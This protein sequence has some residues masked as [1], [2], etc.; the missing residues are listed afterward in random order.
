M[1]FSFFDFYENVLKAY[2]EYYYRE[3]Y[4]LEYHLDHDIFEVIDLTKL[5]SGNKILNITSIYH[6]RWDLNN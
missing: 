1:L 3:G 2:K 4:S 5:D 6:G